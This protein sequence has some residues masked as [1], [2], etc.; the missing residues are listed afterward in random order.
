[1]PAGLK[2]KQFLDPKQC[3][4][5]WNIHEGSL[6]A[7][8]KKLVREGNLNPKTDQPPTISGIEKAAFAW[9]LE[10][11]EEARKDL[12]FAWS[13]EG[14]VLTEEDWREFLRN[15]ARLVFYQRPNRLQNFMSEN[16]FSE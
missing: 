13:R 7:V 1:M 15:A 9:A 10:N 3:W 12:E 4:K 8:Q 5:D 11:Q 6:G 2:N 16:G 14:H